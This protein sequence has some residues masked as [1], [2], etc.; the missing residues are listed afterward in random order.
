M[1]FSTVFLIF[2][3]FIVMA[4]AKPKDEEMD[5]PKSSNPEAPRPSMHY[6]SDEPS[7]PEPSMTDGYMKDDAY[8]YEDEEYG[9][10]YYDDMEGYPS[11]SE[12]ASTSA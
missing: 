1:K 10:E 7:M 3:I 6:N 8:Y 4:M 12:M 11:G 2:V 5:K 9:C